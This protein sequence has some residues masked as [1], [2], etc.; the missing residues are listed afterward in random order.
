MFNVCGLNVGSDSEHAD[1]LGQTIAG[2]PDNLQGVRERERSDAVTEW[3][4][5][6][7]A[8]NPERREYGI[9]HIVRTTL[10]GTGSWI[11]PVYFPSV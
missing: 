5:R 7:R 1:V 11:V 9:T 2:T 8:I 3:A 4:S 6:V 10:V